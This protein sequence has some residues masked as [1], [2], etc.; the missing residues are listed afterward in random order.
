M[1]LNW[2]ILIEGL[3]YGRRLLRREGEKA[4]NQEIKEMDKKIQELFP[5]Q[6]MKIS[7]RELEKNLVFVAQEIG[8]VEGGGANKAGRNLTHFKD[9]ID[10]DRGEA[11]R[12]LMSQLEGWAVARTALVDQMDLSVSSAHKLLLSMEKERQGVVG[13]VETFQNKGSYIRLT[14]K[15]NEPLLVHKYPDSNQNYRYVMASLNYVAQGAFKSYRPGNEFFS[16]GG[17]VAVLH[18]RE[19]SELKKAQEMQ[20]M[21]DKVKGAIQF[22][23]SYELNPVNGKVMMVTEQAGAGDIIDVL[24]H[25]SSVDKEKLVHLTLRSVLEMLVGLH[26]EGKVHRDI[27]PENLFVFTDPTKG[28]GGDA[29]SLSNEA[30][31]DVKLGDYG[32]MIDE[33]E[34]STK[35]IR[36]TYDYYSPELIGLGR[37]SAASDIWAL[38]LSLLKIRYG[39][40]CMR[41]NFFNSDIS[42]LDEAKKNG[43]GDKD[44]IDAIDELILEML[45]EDP[46]ERPSA[47]KALERYKCITNPR[48][49]SAAHSS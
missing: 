48:A 1:N 4:L 14:N 26:G 23:G 17:S 38:G 8:Y 33:R 15:K 49:K 20:E 34:C 37:Q 16:G 19:Q 29:S 39:I 45:A 5:E 30:I 21:S 2:G 18:T 42:Y 36:G 41:N 32:L 24:D 47:E 25:N 13:G 9:L 43:L 40:D 7:S 11:M 12:L 10:T 28:S 46:K 3:N 6:K 44:E 31:V 27:K 22:F 35:E